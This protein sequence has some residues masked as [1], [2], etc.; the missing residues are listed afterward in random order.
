LY[1]RARQGVV[2]GVR[3][4]EARARQGVVA[5]ARQGVVGGAS[6]YYPLHNQYA[7]HRGMT[8]H[9]TAF[10]IAFDSFKSE[11][12]PGGHVA[13]GHGTGRAPVLLPALASML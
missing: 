10:D 6:V 9:S 12:K 5:R 8:A 1:A 4:E 3:I 11:T 2:G 13:L 7:T